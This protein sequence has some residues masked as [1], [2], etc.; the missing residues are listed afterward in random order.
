MSRNLRPVIYIGDGHLEGCGV[1]RILIG[2]MSERNY[3][4]RGFHFTL[5]F[6]ATQG[7][8]S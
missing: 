5:R 7:K 3:R 6:I 2:F 1:R 4:A 8:S